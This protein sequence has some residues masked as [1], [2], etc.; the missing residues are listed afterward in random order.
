MFKLAT[1]CV[2]L[3]CL[4]HSLGASCFV[5]LQDGLQGVQDSLVFSLPQPWNPLFPEAW[6]LL[7]AAVFGDQDPGA[8]CA[9]CF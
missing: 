2:L 9:H 7:E 3:M 8:E 4:H 6:F 5:G 1:S